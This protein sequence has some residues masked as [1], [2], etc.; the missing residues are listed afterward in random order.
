SLTASGVLQRKCASCGNHTT[1]GGKCEECDEKGGLLRRKSNGHS[2]PAEVPP[3]VHEVLNSPGQPLDSR[4]RR[5]FE[6]GFGHD[7]SSV[8]AHTGARAAESAQAV[9]A[10]AYTVGQNIVFGTGEYAPHTSRGQELM[11]HELTHVVQHQGAKSSTDR[12]TLGAH[13]SP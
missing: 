7:F 10:L 12:L 9:N 11:A 3:I 2:E 8:R 6:P 13:D 4:T 1:A 5:V